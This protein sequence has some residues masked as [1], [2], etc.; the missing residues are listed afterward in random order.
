M[1]YDEPTAARIRSLLSSRAVVEKAMF[2]GLCFMVD[3][4]MTCGVSH[5]G[6]LLL[7][8]GP[9]AHPSLVSRPH[10]RPMTFTGRS[11]TGFLYLDP[12]AY[13]TDAQLSRWLT[14]ALSFIATLPRRVA[15]PSRVAPVKKAPAKQRS[16]K[17]TPAGRRASS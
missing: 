6:S 11:L 14:H 3:G 17:K 15:K 12:P 13:R 7:R 16:A 1:A 5:T 10:A 4:H 9:T 8:V 2:G